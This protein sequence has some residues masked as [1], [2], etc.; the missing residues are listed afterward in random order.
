VFQAWLR[1]A[2][3]GG[4]VR[5]FELTTRVT[6]ISRGDGRSA[7]AAAAYRA[8]CVIECEREGKTHDYSRKHGLEAS[9]IVLPDHAPAWA[10]DR[11]KLWNAAELV[12]KNGQRGKNAGKFK[13]DA[14]T[15]RDVLFTY[16]SELSAAGRLNAARVIAR[17]VI[18]TSAAAVDINIHQPGKDG[19]ERNHHCHMMFTTRR[20][21]AKGLGE[22]TREWDHLKT[23]PKLSKALRKFIADTLNAELAAEGKAG[24]ARVEYLSFKARGSPRK[25]TQQHQG[26]GKTHALRKQQMQLRKAWE[27]AQRKEQRERHG[28]ERASLKIRQDF[29]LQ[30]KLAEL[31]KREKQGIEAIDRDLDRQR[32]A[33]IPATGFRRVFQIATKQDMKEAFNRQHR[34]TQRIEA[35][36]QQKADLKAALQAER[37]QFV[38]GQV[39]DRERLTER[40]RGEDQQMQQAVE[41]R[42][43]LDRTAEV[44]ARSNDNRSNS[45]EQVQE[46]EQGRGRSIGREIPPP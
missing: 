24:I 1:H 15:A 37:N 44:H 33:D 39:E 26:P 17:H 18:A 41:Q 4:I 19:D 9:E 13:A 8:C 32:R 36:E 14:K 29:G 40:H 38:R 30:T 34:E 20:M 27:Q 45:R 7:T 12:E 25:A 10:R 2:G 3:S 11:A 21:T 5:V 46:R 28:K 22:K 6:G 23:G 16:P 35:G 42:K 43:S 31:Q